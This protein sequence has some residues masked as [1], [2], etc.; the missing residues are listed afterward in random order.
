MSSGAVQRV[1]ESKNLTV[2]SAFKASMR[3]IFIKAATITSSR[4]ASSRHLKQFPVFIELGDC[5]LRLEE[6]NLA[7]ETLEFARSSYKS[8]ARLMAILGEAYYHIDDISK[9]LSQLQ[10]AFFIDPSRLIYLL[11]AKPIVELAAIVR[12]N[13]GFKR[14]R[15][16]D[17]IYGYIHDIFYVKRN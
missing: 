5:F 11:K 15:R 3:Y 12:R 8:N 9:S 14:H 4:S 10:G 2:S 6:Y 7:I 16:M 17:A 13:G 1:C